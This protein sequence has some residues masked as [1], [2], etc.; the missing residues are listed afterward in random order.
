MSVVFFEIIWILK[1]CQHVYSFIPGQASFIAVVGVIVT[2][3]SLKH[4]VLLVLFIA[5]ASEMI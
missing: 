2:L 5:V 4:L 3:S 1:K